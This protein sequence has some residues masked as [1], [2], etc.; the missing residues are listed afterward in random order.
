MASVSISF[1]KDTNSGLQR[2]GKVHET[3]GTVTITG[4][5][6][7]TKVPVTAADFGFGTIEGIDAGPVYGEGV[8]G[9]G[10]YLGAY[11]DSTNSYIELIDNDGAEV[12]A[13]YDCDAFT[14]PARVRGR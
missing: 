9:T 10:T 4:T 14:F 11:Y 1:S 12:A 7:S 3:R 5:Y 13:N 6:V 2:I 8:T